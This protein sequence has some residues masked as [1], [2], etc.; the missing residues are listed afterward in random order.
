MQTLKSINE[1][2]LLT[3]LELLPSNHN[4]LVIMQKLNCINE[5][6]LLT[7]LESLPS[8]HN[9][10]VMYAKVRSINKGKLFTLLELLPSNHNNLGFQSVCYCNCGYN[11]CLLN[12]LTELV[13]L[14]RL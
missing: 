4:N 14:S 7:L 8:N 9:N 5:G 10:L 3:L 6:K 1:G 13:V 11:N 2:K 12:W